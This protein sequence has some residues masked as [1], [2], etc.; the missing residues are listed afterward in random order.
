MNAI[1][2]VIWNDA[3]RQ[4]QVVNE[5]C[6]SR[7]KA[8]SV[9]AVHTD[10]AGRSLKR[11]V[12]A[13]AAATLIGSAA[14]LGVPG[15]VWADDFNLGVYAPDIEINIGTGAVNN[16][17]PPKVDFSLLPG[18]N[19]TI[20][21]NQSRFTGFAS[22]IFNQE[23]RT[24]P[25]Y[26]L[27]TTDSGAMVSDINL[28]IL[29]ADG[30]PL[31]L[32]NNP[33]GT[34][35]IANFYYTF[36]NTRIVDGFLYVYRTLN[37][38]DLTSQAGYGQ[39]FDV[40]DS[41]GADLKAAITGDGNIT[42]SYNST[43]EGGDPGHLTLSNPDGVN[44]ENTYTGR[45]FVGYNSQ[46]AE[47]SPV[48]IYFG[49]DGALGS[50]IG[51]EQLQIAA[52]SAVHFGGEN[53]DK[54]YIQTV[55][56][57]SGSGLLHLGTQAKLTLNQSSSD[58]GLVPDEA[59]QIIISNRYAGSGTYNAE[60]GTYSDSGAVFNVNLSGEVA[61]YELVF[62]DTASGY[63]GLINL[64]NATV[65][66][67][68]TDRTVRVDGI[69][70]TPNALLESAT[71]QLQS[72]GHLKVT[73]KGSVHNLI[74]AHENTSIVFDNLDLGTGILE[75]DNLS[76]QNTGKVEIDN[77]GSGLQGAADDLGYLEADGGI[78]QEIIRV[79]GTIV[80][81]ENDM[82]LA[83]DALQEKQTELSTDDVEADLYWNFDPNLIFNAEDKTYSA[84]YGLTKVNVESGQFALEASEGATGATADF[85]AQITG[86]G[87]LLI[88]ASGTQVTLGNTADGA[89]A[90]TYSGAT[91]VTTGTDV[92]LAVD[93]AMG[94]TSA[95][96][97]AGNVEL[98]AGVEQKILGLTGS[99][100]LTMGLGAVLTLEQ[101]ADAMLD[102]NLSGSGTFRV[103]GTG[104]DKI[105]LVFNNTFNYSGALDFSNVVF[106]LREGGNR[107]A[108][109]SA[110]IT[111]TNSVLHLGQ[112]GGTF[113]N[114][115][116]NSGVQFDD[117]YLVI[118]SDVPALSGTGSLVFNAN[119]NINLAGISVADNIALID[120]DENT[121]YQDFISASGGI[122]THGHSVT[123][124]GSNLDSYTGA[125][126]QN[127]HV[128]ANTTWE[129]S[130]GLQMSDATSLQ[131]GAVLTGI[132]LTGGELVISGAGTLSAAI[133]E[134][135]NT[136]DAA[137]RFSLADG[138][139]SS[140]M[141]V[142]SE[143]ND[144]D[145]AVAVD[146]GVTLWLDADH[147]LGTTSSLT[148]GDNATVSLKDGVRQ[149]VGGLAGS[150]T[151][152]LGSGSAFTLNRNGSTS[153]AASVTG[154]Q[155]STFTV[156][157]GGSSNALSFADTAAD[158]AYSG[159]FVLEN[160]L[161]QFADNSNAERV[162][163][164]STFVLSGGAVID[165]QNGAAGTL[166][167]LVLEGG[168]LRTHQT[169]LA[170]A[171]NAQLIVTG[172]VSLASNTTIEAG[173]I[174]L[175]GASDILCADND[176][177]VRQVFVQYSG[178]YKPTEGAQ[179][180]IAGGAL[181]ESD[182][183]ND[184]NT[185]DVVAHGTWSGSVGVDT[186]GKQ[187]YGD[188]QLTQIDLI[189]TNVGLILNASDADDSSLSALV[190][191]SGNL[192]LAGDITI[193]GDQENAY[194][195]TTTVTAGTVTLGK[196]N[197]FGATSLLTVSGGNVAFNNQSTQI[198][199][200]Q[201]TQ[202]GSLAGG[203]AITLFGSSTQTDIVGANT[204]LSAS[205]SVLSGHTATIHDPQ[206]LGTGG[207]G[208]SG[209]S[210][211][212]LD[213]R[214]QNTAFA[215]VLT[216]GGSLQIGNGTDAAAVHING[217]NSGF[218][219]NINIAANA[220]LLASGAKVDDNLGTGVIKFAGPSSTLHL[221]S[222]T[223][224]DIT[225]D[226]AFSGA[227]SL[228]VSGTGSNQHF[229]FETSGWGKDFNGG[230][231]TLT[232]IAMRVGSTVNYGDNN[233]AN[234][235][236]ANL[237]L[238]ANAILEVSSGATVD[239]FNNLLLSGGS[240]SFDGTAGFNAG[241]DLADLHID[242]TLKLDSGNIYIVLPDQSTDMN[243]S[244]GHDSLLSTAAG[245]MF[246]TLIEA[247]GGVFPGAFPTSPS[248]VLA[249]RAIQVRRILRARLAGV[250]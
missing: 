47:T 69:D 130:S 175:S 51:T 244:L 53:D 207:I 222:N 75:I 5:L 234:L 200:I 143:A 131:A 164:T 226:N 95:L 86:S 111:L 224:G 134:A 186:E 116:V 125:Y 77:I 15:S 133:T 110:D 22:N 201:S 219:G 238:N 98:A 2:K 176:E 40:S 142:S 59:G 106:D 214:D 38:I 27:E 25:L 150:G 231:L 179:L 154:G 32:T 159:R 36:D 148:V 66:A 236:Q 187:I 168:T 97:A 96:E 18:S 170:D 80:G 63:T 4:Y 56:G 7:R 104:T 62:T 128:V 199:A 70:Y 147:A 41:K 223:T 92:I 211:L 31:D 158:T 153:L 250:A 91:T 178:E 74:I 174:I 206:G 209:G 90:N 122:A 225:I 21:I 82:V 10:G 197:A 190:T 112:S 227:G 28:S 115:T 232:G 33:L 71:L 64:T 194:S 19:E 83:G 162:L 120:F 208:L 52:Q 139:T 132:E 100:T 212:I 99:G 218:S 177:G 84:K 163:G 152:N 189:D 228:Y 26:L 12:L 171:G 129:V 114:M 215:N 20:Y 1:Y 180:N 198:G 50:T 156:N 109:A 237:A 3:I 73:D 195:G 44:N 203:G 76:L 124:V 39:V 172:D 205:I 60:S 65:T 183:F 149:T 102:N 193:E 246:E 182:I 34:T 8:C 68:D 121:R 204:G 49:K 78:T 245:G 233:A 241:N 54:A 188:L 35:D 217:T 89:P 29:G 17:E 127:G 138:S 230:T 213:Y 165:L 79:S 94:N 61:G 239:T 105:D 210:T 45:T 184:G 155:S 72:G 229:G 220:D 101:N 135:E 161:L 30:Q 16:G 14:L 173:G 11:S 46:G 48:N 141:R 6:R 216:G 196:T 192:T 119:T 87:G 37:R 42:F 247:E 181:V 113:D 140:T 93:N 58:T 235:A 24:P 243:G 160:S 85:T 137:I 144:F 13:T 117:V 136:Q 67:Y 191:G 240:V 169:T 167:N 108:A 249:V 107:S 242:G 202:G 55:R 166:G 248:I 146:R 221:T 157:L 81:D 118:G 185:T 88:D 23:E 123:L 57:L 103:T 9:K 43:G 145:A 151:V 126:S